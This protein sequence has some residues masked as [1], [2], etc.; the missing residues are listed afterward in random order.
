VKPSIFQ[1]ENAITLNQLRCFLSVV[2]FSVRHLLT[3]ELVLTSC[4]R[5]LSLKADKY[6]NSGEQERDNSRSYWNRHTKG[7]SG[8]CRR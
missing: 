2:I 6:E 7:K 8:E 5:S 1:K 3:G 4:V